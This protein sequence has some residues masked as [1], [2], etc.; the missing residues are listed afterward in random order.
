MLLIARE[1]QAAA[2]VR[3]VVVVVAVLAWV[4]E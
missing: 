2:L 3:V 1:N 4:V